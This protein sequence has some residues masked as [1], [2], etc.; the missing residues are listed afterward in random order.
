MSIIN[1]YLCD[2]FY[3]DNA[4]SFRF[5]WEETVW[6]ICSLEGNPPSKRTFEGNEKLGRKNASPTF[7]I[8]YCSHRDDF[9]QKNNIFRG[10]WKKK[11][12]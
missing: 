10:F 5:V 6:N 8:I 9:F 7:F 12:W 3:V 11:K 1:T 4:N 2:V